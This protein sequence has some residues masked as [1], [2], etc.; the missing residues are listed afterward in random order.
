MLAAIKAFFLT[1][2]YF[3]IVLPYGIDAPTAARVRDCSLENGPVV[4]EETAQGYEA[5]FHVLLQQTYRPVLTKNGLPFVE[6]KAFVPD[7]E[8]EMESEHE[9]LKYFQVIRRD[10]EYPPIQSGWTYE[11]MGDPVLI[12]VGDEYTLTIRVTL[13]KGTAPGAYSLAMAASYAQ[14]CVYMDAL[15]VK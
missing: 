4:C 10:E 15:I 1:I 14:E 3:F 8:S 2:V 7:D 11:L 6:V 13:P 9:N 12:R 5:E